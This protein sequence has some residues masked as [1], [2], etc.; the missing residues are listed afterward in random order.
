MRLTQADSGQTDRNMLNARAM[1]VASK[2][3]KAPSPV[4]TAASITE[5]TTRDEVL[6]ESS[7]KLSRH[8]PSTPGPRGYRLAPRSL[9]NR[10]QTRHQLILIH[11]R[12][13]KC[14]LLC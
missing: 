6:K 1:A 10:T 14:Q 5:G 12:Q 13:A 3:S 8:R 9:I 11:T 7:A 4:L 2:T